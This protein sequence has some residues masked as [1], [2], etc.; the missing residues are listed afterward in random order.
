MEFLNRFVPD[1][2]IGQELFLS[3]CFPIRYSVIIMQ[4]KSVLSEPLT[5]SWNHIYHKWIHKWKIF[6]PKRFSVLDF[7]V[8]KTLITRDKDGC[9][10]SLQLAMSNWVFGYRDRFN[11]F[12]ES[13]PPRGG[14]RRL[15][16]LDTMTVTPSRVTRSA[17]ESA[18]TDGSDCCLFI[19]TFA[20]W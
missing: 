13:P 8:L 20:D 7:T 2:A 9:R 5:A 12:G 6:F 19:A 14:R 4:F 17:M 10:D 3:M 18:C 15:G 11:S 1:I 16:Y